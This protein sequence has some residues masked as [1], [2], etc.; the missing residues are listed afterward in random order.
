MIKR[1]KRIIYLGGIY[2]LGTL[3][4][5]GMAFVFIPIYTTYLGTADYGVIGLMTVT[6]GLLSKLFFP[7]VNQGFIRHYYAP[8]FSDRQGLLLFN[9]LLFLTAQALVFS[10]LFFWF[11][12]K[13]AQLVFA[14]AELV[15]IVKVYA[16]ILFFDPIS[17]FLLNY[18]N[19]K[20]RARTIIG[21][22]WGHSLFYAAVV[23]AGLI[24]WDLGVLALIYGTLLGMV[25][26]VICVLPVVF[27][28][29]ECRVVPSVL[30]KPLKYGYPRIISGCSNLLIQS[31]DRYVLMIFSTLSSVGLYNF[32][33]QIS[34]I[35]YSLF[36]V[37]LT[38]ALLPVTFK[39]E[40]DPEQQREFLQKT[41]T[42][43][44]LAGMFACLFLS[45][46]SREFIEIMARKEEFWAGWTI[47]PVIA[48]SY[49]L[50]GLGSF[51]DWGLVMTKNGFQISINVFVGALVNIAGNFLLIPFW[52]IMGAA[53]ATV[54]SFIVLNWMRIHYSAKFYD[55]HF[56][57]RRLFHITAVAIGLYGFSLLMPDSQWLWLNM[58]FKLLVLIAFP[59]I[60][61]AT[62]FFRPQERQ[63]MQSLWENL[64]IRGIRDTFAKVRALN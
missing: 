55:L 45:L 15:F 36:V 20:E 3:V 8:E 18:L 47:I 22:S 44:Y 12:Q 27:K 53:V 59:G 24:I 39:Q 10:L 56:E 51:F 46:Y 42:Y 7:P 54:I 31:G 5:K 61:F 35:I 21:I 41:C 48:F 57:L 4:E 58:A 63:A 38:N 37:P 17:N 29:A 34:A 19:Q 60:I 50:F 40:A 25:F 1:V 14:Q 9:S 6:V 33:Y 23:L 52:G 13:I 16:F 28:E 26:K 62:G 43:F 32:G 30:V 49:I 11:S 2:S 64:R